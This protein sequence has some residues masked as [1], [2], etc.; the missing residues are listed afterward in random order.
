M[1]F[2]SFVVSLLESPLHGVIDRGVTALRI[3]G[4]RTGRQYVLPVQYARTDETILLDGVWRNAAGVA[5][6][7]VSP[8]VVIM[9][10]DR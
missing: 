9:M 6:D 4:R 10:G 3:T 7:R 8:I 1:W 2:N 5:L